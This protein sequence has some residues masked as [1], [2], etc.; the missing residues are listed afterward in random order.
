MRSVTLAV[1][2][3]PPDGDG[4]L[5]RKRPAGY[6][7]DLYRILVK[8]VFK[9]QRVHDAGDLERKAE[10]LADLAAARYACLAKP[11]QS[12][13]ARQQFR[14]VS[15]IGARR[16]VDEHAEDRRVLCSPNIFQLQK[17]AVRGSGFRRRYQSRSY[18][19]EYGRV[20]PHRS[21]H[22]GTFD[23]QRPVARA[24]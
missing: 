4:R 3:D 7:R 21:L 10:P 19:A 23:W 17:N 16:K 12:H 1:N 9:V 11:K 6:Y 24:D 22:S 18:L 13:A 5:V 15:G 8:L 20:Q 14:M 2:A